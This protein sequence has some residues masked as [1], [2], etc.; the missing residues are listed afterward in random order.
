M[1]MQQSKVKP[2]VIPFIL[3]TAFLNLAGVGLIAP[4]LP[5]IT[6]QYVPADQVDFVAALLFSAYSLCQFIAVP[7]L[8]AMSDRCGRRPILIISLFGSAIGYLLFGI[9]GALWVLFA[10]R[11]I[12]GLTG[13]NIA[14]IFAY[15]ADIT[16][17][18]ERTKFFGILGAV[19][20]LGFVFGP[21]MGGILYTVTQSV[22]APLYFA[23]ALTLVNMLWGFFAMPESLT[24]DKR[25][26][27]VSLARL[28]PFAQL[29]D[30]FR[31]AQIRYLLL[32][33]FLWAFAFAVLQSNI[34]VLAQTRLGWNPDGVSLVLFILGVL[35][36]L[37]QGI[38]IR[39]ALPVLGEERLAQIG[40]GWQVIGFATLILL[41]LTLTP[42]LLFVGVI[43]AG[44]GN[45][46][47]TPTLTGMLSQSVGPREQGRVQ[48]GSQSVQALARVAGPAFI[49]GAL[50]LNNNLIAAP[51]IASTAAL[52][53]AFFLV[54][55][56]VPVFR[57][58]RV[59]K[60]PVMAYAPEPVANEGK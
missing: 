38:F 9:G 52:V 14:T 33:T 44:I 39:R 30:V 36:I 23:A 18:Q 7:T 43:I 42:A 54:A 6:K 46:L 21:A 57:S 60:T 26:A 31:I 34:G 11:I 17:P 53:M 8:G 45:S 24:P 29:A 20:G 2:G 3:I 35:G 25:S 19:S 22:A 58:V 4:V 16:E 28:N 47:V 10:G 5:A 55:A 15:A 41:A 48:G 1:K 27:N 12:D 40:L 49:S 59:Q 13:G 50:G 37:V 32:A 56:A 51:Y